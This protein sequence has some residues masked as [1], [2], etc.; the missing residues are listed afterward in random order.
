M[1]VGNLR[2]FSDVY[3]KEIGL[4]SGLKQGIKVWVRS[5]IG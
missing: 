2:P 3:A 5:E 1:K 4:G